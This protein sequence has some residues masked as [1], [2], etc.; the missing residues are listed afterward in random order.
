MILHVG[1]T[2]LTER[3]E[4]TESH[5][6]VAI[7]I[8]HRPHL[9]QLPIAHPHARIAASHILNSLLELAERDGATAIGIRHIEDLT[10]A[11]HK[12]LVHEALE[13]GLQSLGSS[14]A[15]LV[16]LHFLRVRITSRPIQVGYTSPQQ[17]PY[18]YLLLSIYKFKRRPD[19]ACISVP[20]CT[21]GRLGPRTCE[22]TAHERN[23]R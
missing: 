5:R 4:L 3:S 19:E 10:E 2:T 7:D 8:N 18:V 6:I 14:T 21:V 9:L 16:I 1:S 15:D 22:V 11:A 23:A 20:D 13:L 17:C 12:A